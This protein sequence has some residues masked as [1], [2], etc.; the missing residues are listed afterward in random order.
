MTWEANFVKLLQEQRN[1]Q[2]GENVTD[3]V[4]PG[5][6]FNFAKLVK[7]DLN[8]EGSAEGILVSL[9]AFGNQ[10]LDMASAE[11]RLLG[12]ASGVGT[13]K[14]EGKLSGVGYKLNNGNQDDPENLV[15]RTA[16]LEKLL[17]DG[18]YRLA[19]SFKGEM[20]MPTDISSVEKLAKL[21]QQNNVEVLWDKRFLANPSSGDA[22]PKN[23]GVK[24]DPLVIKDVL[25]WGQFLAE[26][27]IFSLKFENDNSF[28]LISQQALQQFVA[29][30]GKE[31]AIQRAAYFDIL[32]NTFQAL[33]ANMVAPAYKDKEGV[34]ILANSPEAAQLTAAMLS[35]KNKQEH[36]REVTVAYSEFGRMVTIDKK[37]WEKASTIPGINPTV[38]GTNDSFDVAFTDLSGNKRYFT[39]AWVSGFFES[40]GTLGNEVRYKGDPYRKGI[41]LTLDN[42]PVNMIAKASELDDAANF[43]MNPKGLWENVGAFFS[44]VWNSEIKSRDVVSVTKEDGTTAYKYLRLKD[45][46]LYN[47]E[48]QVQENLQVGVGPDGKKQTV[49]VFAPRAGTGASFWWWSPDT[50]SFKNSEGKLVDI[51]PSKA[52][53]DPNL[54]DQSAGMIK[55]MK[56]DAQG[57]EIVVGAV[58]LAQLFTGD[59]AKASDYLKEPDKYVRLEVSP[60]V[61]EF[62]ALTSPEQKEEKAQLVS[63]GYSSLSHAHNAKNIFTRIW[64][65][66]Q[67]DNDAEVLFTEGGKTFGV[68]VNENSKNWD[69]ATRKEY[70]D[71]ETKELLQYAGPFS[72]SARAKDYGK[73]VLSG[74]RW[75]TFGAVMDTVAVATVVWGVVSGIVKGLAAGGVRWA[76][77]MVGEEAVPGYGK[78][79]H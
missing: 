41:A 19:L 18:N 1:K 50:K 59:K 52:F 69:Y 61:Y 67:R 65:W 24:F 74:E 72:D 15:E 35:D 68:Y 12:L 36:K 32:I 63:W 38:N 4:N 3:G 57:N 54:S 7:A 28:N 26:G 2:L 60:G 71:P 73:T 53:G 42:K 77:A 9:P 79:D 14:I 22:R 23:E 31:K 75:A 27:G 45:N 51:V 33:P 11:M 64:N 49:S 6:I 20:V 46:W 58:P 34:L 5:Q 13:V 47:S 30:P 25:K 21:N 62:R 78:Y 29:A 40:Q 70:S 17:L 37:D 55:L 8:I 66:E 16:K 39:K 56:K 76:V 10:T 44:F 43:N 48:G